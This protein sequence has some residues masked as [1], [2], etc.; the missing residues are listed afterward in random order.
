MSILQLLLVAILLVAFAMFVIKGYLRNR[1]NRRFARRIVAK[2]LR[3]S[4]DDPFDIYH[5]YQ[6]FAVI[7]GGHSP[8]AEQVASGRLDDWSVRAFNFHCE[9]G[10]GTRRE[11]RYYS[12]VVFETPQPLPEFC[13]W[14]QMNAEMAPLEFRTSAGKLDGWRYSGD[15]RIAKSLAEAMSGE[16]MHNGLVQLNGNAVMF[17]LPQSAKME[18]C[19]ADWIGRA[20]DMMVRL[21][22]DLKISTACPE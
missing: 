9:V 3:F 1:R 15:E 6:K 10:H 14:S 11:T 12:I 21:A 2:G 5:R 19:F 22:G 13:L 8:I 16:N 20:K 17:C 18:V 7:N 4:I